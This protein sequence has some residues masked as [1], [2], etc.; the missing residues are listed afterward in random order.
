LVHLYASTA[1]GRPSRFYRLREI[2]RPSLQLL[3]SPSKQVVLR[4]T[5]QPGRT[6]EIQA[7]QNFK[8]WTVI[9]TATMGL[10]VSVDASDGNAS[11]RTSRF[12]RLREILN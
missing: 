1:A 3:I 4:I 8:T 2:P 12:Y 10:G 9:G 5:G 6:Y 7:T 11:A